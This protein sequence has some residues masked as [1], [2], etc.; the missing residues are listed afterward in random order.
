MMS[1]GDDFSWNSSTIFDKIGNQDLREEYLT[2]LSGTGN[3][4]REMIAQ[5]RSLNQ[6]EMK[7]ILYDLP[8]EDREE[9]LQDYYNVDKKPSLDIN[10]MPPSQEVA[11]EGPDTAPSSGMMEPLELNA[12]VNF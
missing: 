12:S 4:E 6:T 2:E 7:S 8:I 3:T 9:F 11:A 10:N 1:G 5:L